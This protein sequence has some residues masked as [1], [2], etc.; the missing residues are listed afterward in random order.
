M[1]M[2]LLLSTQSPQLLIKI[3]FMGIT[4]K[5]EYL[6]QSTNFHSRHKIPDLHHLLSE[7]GISYDLGPPSGME[8]MD[9]MAHSVKFIALKE[10]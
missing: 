3:F 9:Q 5:L 10:H 6:F 8:I 1:E 2:F 7:R 4:N